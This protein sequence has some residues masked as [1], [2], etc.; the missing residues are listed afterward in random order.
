MQAEIAANREADLELR[1]ML[2]RAREDEAAVRKKLEIVDGQRQDMSRRLAKAELE[3]SS[4]S[5]QVRCCVLFFT[6]DMPRPLKLQVMHFYSQATA[7]AAEADRN[8]RHVL[9]TMFPPISFVDSS[10]EPRLLHF[11]NPEMVTTTLPPVCYQL[12]F[13]SSF[14]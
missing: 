2:R 6:M 10:F 9:S 1:K 7:L 11:G 14:R 8:R 12:F 3:R 13:P 4:L 5:K